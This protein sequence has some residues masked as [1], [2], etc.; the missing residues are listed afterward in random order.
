MQ[1][2][3]VRTGRRGSRPLSANDSWVLWGEGKGFSSE[4]WMAIN[5]SG[6]KIIQRS[7]VREEK[8][9]LDWRSRL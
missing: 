1:I 8:N 4:G 2:S 3:G 9:N 5:K 7:I 6:A